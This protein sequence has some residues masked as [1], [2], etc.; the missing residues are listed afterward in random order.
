[1][2]IVTS[3]GCSKGCWMF[4]RFP[5]WFVIFICKLFFEDRHF[6]T[7]LVD[8]NELGRVFEDLIPEGLHPFWDEYLPS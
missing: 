6:T 4:R 5:D 8:V 7:Q 3:G 2:N 1:M